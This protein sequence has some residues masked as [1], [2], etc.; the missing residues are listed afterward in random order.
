MKHQ[1]LSEKI[2]A[3]AYAVHKELGCGFVE[4]VYKNALAIQ[5]EEMGLRCICEVPLRVL[6]HAKTV[7]EYFADIV[8]EDTIIV[9]TK[10]VSRLDAVHEVQLV[11]YLKGTGLTIGLLINFGRSVEVKRRVFDAPPR[12]EEP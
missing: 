2:I 7:G 10:A 8:V 4:K 3:A 5:L 12:S 11:N 1:E 6:Y 9:E